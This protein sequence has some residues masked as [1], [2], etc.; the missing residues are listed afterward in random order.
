MIQGFNPFFIRSVVPTLNTE[1]QQCFT[2]GCFNPFFI[3][4]VVPTGTPSQ[5]RRKPL[6]EFQSLLHQV[7]GAN[8]NLIQRR[9]RKEGC[10]NPF[11]IRS[12]VPTQLRLTNQNP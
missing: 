11:F 5:W 7:S 6:A 10:F 12:V 1:W 9:L 2:K 3:R 4:S 8:M